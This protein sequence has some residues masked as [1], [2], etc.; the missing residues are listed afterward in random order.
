MSRDPLR[1]PDYLDHIL[2][3]RPLTVTPICSILP[4]QHDHPVLP[5]PAGI[6]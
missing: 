5:V 6:Q 2:E 1:V 3:A 4:R